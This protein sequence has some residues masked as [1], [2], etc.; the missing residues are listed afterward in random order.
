MDQHWPILG[1][2]P[3]CNLNLMWASPCCMGIT[4]GT[5]GS[6]V[7]TIRVKWQLLGYLVLLLQRIMG[8]HPSMEYYYLYQIFYFILFP[9]NTPLLIQAGYYC[10][11]LF[12]F[13]FYYHNTSTLYTEYTEIH[14]TWYA[15]TQ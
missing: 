12:L 2:S 3:E 15:H 5:G 1:V 6:G 10:F 13:L 9:S 14:S 7:N 4:D 8:Y 11:F